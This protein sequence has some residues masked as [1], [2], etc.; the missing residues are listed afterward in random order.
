MEFM[1]FRMYNTPCLVQKATNVE[2]SPENKHLAL[3][4]LQHIII[5]SRDGIEHSKN[6]G[7]ILKHFHYTFDTLNPK[8]CK[9]FTEKTDY[10]WQVISPRE[11]GMA[12]DYTSA[13]LD[14]Q[15]FIGSVRIEIVL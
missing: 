8:R 13:N 3:A 6:V 2:M 5:L 1:P 11:C 15:S 12:D 4:H 14:L 9:Y 7:T 10:H